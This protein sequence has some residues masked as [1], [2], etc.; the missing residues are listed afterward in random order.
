MSIKTIF[1][2]SGFWRDS[3]AA[4]AVEFAIVAPFLVVVLINAV[5]FF[6]GFRGDRVVSRTN[7]VVLDLLTREQGAIDDDDL[8]ELIAI[9]EALAGKYVD[10][11]FTLVLTSVRNTWDSEENPDIDLRWSISND[12]SAVLTQDDIDA[13]TLPSMQE[14]DTAIISSLTTE[15]TPAI[16]GELSGEFTLSD[17]LI[18][19][20]RYVTEIDCSSDS[21]KC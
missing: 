19:R 3:S 20:P 7:T 2:Q 4:A 18:R 9:A 21:G 10:N 6:D 5:S 15:Y 17:Y 1:Q 14:G 11:G 8:D 13:M 12:S 16:V